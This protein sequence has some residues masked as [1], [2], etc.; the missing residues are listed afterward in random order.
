MKIS[1]IAKLV[2]KTGCVQL[3]RV[4]AN[5]VYLGAGGAAVY[6]TEGLPLISGRDQAQIILDLT[7]EQME[8]V[9]VVEDAGTITHIGLMDINMKADDKK[10]VEWEVQ[11]IEAAAIVDGRIV[12]LLELESGEILSFNS[13][14]LTPLKEEQ[15]SPYFKL[16]VREN[17]E[18]KKYIVAYDGL[19]IKAAIMPTVL[20]DDYFKKLDKFLQAVDKIRPQN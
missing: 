4:D 5:K 1:K 15:Q 11:R 2:K 14:F 17:D 13:D 12:D 8:K 7:R 3:I 16:R 18:H 20:T 9:D 6:A 10:V 19:F